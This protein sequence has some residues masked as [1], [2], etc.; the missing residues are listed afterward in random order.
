VRTRLTATLMA[1]LA[2]LA[3]PAP[4]FA[5]VP[6]LTSQIT[7]HSAGKAADTETAA[8][9]GATVLGLVIFASRTWRRRRLSRVGCGQRR[10]TGPAPGPPTEELEAQ[11]SR[12]LV[13]TDDSV[14]ASEQE[15]GFAVAKFGE[16]AAA[17]FSA[18]LTSAKAEL[19]AAFRLRQVLDDRQ[20]SESARRSVLTEITAHCAE[21]S[22]LL[23]EQAE[24]FDRLQ[25]S[26]TR[27]PMVL[28]EV[29]AHTIQQAARLG[30]SRQM[31]NHLAAKYTAQAVAAVAANP[32]QAAERLKFASGSLADAKW[33][34]V[35]GQN[36]KAAVVLRAAESAADQASDLLD[37]VRHLEAE[38]TQASSALPAA[39]R[40]IDLDI[41]EATALVE[42]RPDGQRAAV[43]TKARAAAAAVRS[44]LGGD[45]FDALAALRALAEADAAL[46][47]LLAAGRAER[48]RQ[49][50]A[51]A[52]LD[53]AM[54]VARSS[55]TTAE[56][57][58]STRRG[59]VREPARTRLAEAHRRF[60]QAIGYVPANAEAAVNEAQQADALAQQARSLAGQD[61]AQSEDGRPDFMARSGGFGAGI[62]HRS[63]GPGGLAE[64]ETDEPG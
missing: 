51:T 28:A 55:I 29:D 14:R 32:E 57:F 16:Q 46:D 48:A 3:W 39:L 36:G 56:D 15:L 2:S 18:A 30:R 59:G 33:Q 45:P 9:V 47:Q 61:V 38:L 40:E 8:I 23:D 20:H 43:V 53:Q 31:L 49:D 44:Q 7:D 54:L 63:A 22:R 27:A 6:L 1:G 52:V 26:E 5:A 41:T 64:P 42:G 12:L 21:A 58:I 11:A 62:G 19:A 50:R 4:T 13:Q 24:A 17:P 35:A 60:R 37:G 10:G 25:D 34:L